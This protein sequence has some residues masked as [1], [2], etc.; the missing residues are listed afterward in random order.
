MIMIPKRSE[1]VIRAIQELQSSTG[2]PKDKRIGLTLF[3]CLPKGLITIRDFAEYGGEEKLTEDMQLAEQMGIVEQ[4][5][6]H[7]YR[8]NRHRTDRPPELTGR[9]KRLMT[10]LYRHFSRSWFSSQD[11]STATSY[12]K[13]TLSSI[14]HRFILLKL[15]ESQGGIYKYYRLRIDPVSCP[16][17]FDIETLN[18][19]R[20][21]K[22]NEA[23]RQHITSEQT[24]CPDPE[25]PEIIDEPYSEEF[26]AM[27][28]RLESSESA[29][30][31]RI[32]KALRDNM[33][34][35]Y[36]SM[37]DYLTLGHSRSKWFKDMELASG[38]GL[39]YTGKQGF[40]T[41]NRTLEPRHNNMQPTLKKAITDIYQA[42][43]DQIFT[44]EMFI[45]TLKYSET[46]SY[47]S[48]HK[49]A[50]M[51]V[52]DLQKTEDGNQYQLLVNPKDNPEFFDQAA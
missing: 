17:F 24:E 22:K 5:T 50:L 7:V 34:K 19:D 47:A 44:S 11:A 13:T 10:L 41:L 16:C 48:L 33:L 30:D 26:I 42:F 38:L 27:L 29:I 31:N 37:K 25:P 46:H 18:T 21:T 28:D 20:L 9:Q 6:P 12:A 52:I 35:G 43:G 3:S 36:I 1:E 32:S 8:I 39:V 23:Q 49:L 15:A 14:L 4:V 45:A 40:R 51:S 2:S